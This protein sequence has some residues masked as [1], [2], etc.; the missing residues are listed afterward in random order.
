MRLSVSSA[1]L[2]L[3]PI[4]LLSSSSGSPSLASGAGAAVF[5]SMSSSSSLLLP[6][7]LGVCAPLPFSCAGCVP[8]AGGAN[9]SDALRDD[10]LDALV[11]YKPPPAFL[12]SAPNV[13]RLFVDPAAV[14]ADYARRTGI[15]PIMHLLGIRCEI[16]ARDPRLCLRLCQAFEAAR[17]YAVAITAGSGRRFLVLRG[18]RQPPCARGPLPLFPCPGHRRPTGHGRRI[19]RA[20]D[21]GLA[22]ELTGVRLPSMARSNHVAIPRLLM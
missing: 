6:S 13:G 11:A 21:R 4:R 15:F 5:R 18:R 22:A 20:G 7:A 19:I 9:L 14:E 1:L 12:D 8:L 10:V 3:L 17:R 2:A 16:A